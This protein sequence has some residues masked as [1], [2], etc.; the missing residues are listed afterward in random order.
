MSYELRANVVAAAAPETRRSR[1]LAL[2]LL[3]VAAM[4]VVLAT[5]IVAF[6]AETETQLRY[7][8]AQ[9]SNGLLRAASGPGDCRPKQETP[10]TVWPGPTSLCI[11]PDGSVRRFASSKSCMGA[12]PAGTLLVVPT[13]TGEP[14]YFCAPASGVL[15]RV[16]ASTVCLSTEQRYVIGNHAPSGLTLSNDSLLENEPAATVVGTL[17]LV[18]EDPAATPA[19]TLVSGT[20]D[21]DN[22][23]FTITGSTLKTAASFDYETKSSYSCLLYTSP[24]PRD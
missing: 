9:K 12:K 15:R 18:D 11:Q 3:T 1:L 17:G 21:D 6:A 24:S 23:A 5:P 8:C 22:A 16:S 2:V 20:G 7:A 19:F 13:T 10:V 4:I 14:V